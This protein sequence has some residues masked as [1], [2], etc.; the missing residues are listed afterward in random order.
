[1][2]DL[3]LKICLAIVALFG[4]VSA[5]VADCSSEVNSC[6]PKQLCKAAT[7]TEGGVKIWSTDLEYTQHVTAAK[8]FAINCGVVEVLASC[9]N[10]PELCSVKELCKQAVT[11]SDD[12]TSWNTS[13]KAARHVSLA[14]EYDLSCGM[15][16]ATVAKSETTTTPVAPKTSNYKSAFRGQSLLRRKQIQYALKNLGFYYSGIDGLWGKGTSSAIVDYAQSNGVG[17]ISPNGVFHSVL[18]KVDVPNSF[19]APKRLVTKTEL[20][21]EY[22]CSTNKIYIKTPM[23]EISTNKGMTSATLVKGGQRE[24][25]NSTETKAIVKDFKLDQ[26]MIIRFFKDN[27]VKIP[28]MDEQKA[29]SD[30]LKSK[31][32][33][34][35]TKLKKRFE[36]F[37][38]Q[39]HIKSETMLLLGLKKCLLNLV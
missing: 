2:K 16:E 6:T 32:P 23:F 38:L 7:A 26:A 9:E 31:S 5:S 20:F 35:R 12:Q 39:N 13:K 37:I 29:L 36:K 21:T 11:T 33:K 27:T 17:G 10:D 25:L 18:S 14:K 34:N 22:A 3:S 4:S 8:D 24:K 30:L 15:A 19:A 1:M 28:I